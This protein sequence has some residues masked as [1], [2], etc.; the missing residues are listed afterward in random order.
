MESTKELRELLQSEK[1]KPVGWERP[2]GYVLLQR[3]PSIYLTRLALRYNLLPN[4]I[5]LAGIAAGLSGSLLVFYGN[6]FGMAAGV[7]LLYVNILAD[8]V[9]GE[10]A[11]YRI[12]KGSGGVYHRGVYLD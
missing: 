5:T 3:G 8:K 11:R 9:D 12:H 4:H 6:K 2:W 7:F 1:V 10:V